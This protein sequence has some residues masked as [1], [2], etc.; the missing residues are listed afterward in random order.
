MEIIQIGLNML[1][2]SAKDRMEWGFAHF[3][4]GLV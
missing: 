2:H 1:S 4:T 3:S